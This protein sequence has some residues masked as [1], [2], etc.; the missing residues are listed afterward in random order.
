MSDPLVCFCPN[1]EAWRPAAN[2]CPECAGEMIEPEEPA[3][4]ILNYLRRIALALEDS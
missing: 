3:I 2:F 1:C 4:P